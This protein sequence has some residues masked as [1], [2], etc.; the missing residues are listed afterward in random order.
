MLQTNGRLTISKAKGCYVW[1]LDNKKYLDMSLM[2]V[3]TN[4]LG[5]SNNQVDNAVIKAIRNSNMS[6]L[7]CPEEI[8]LSEKLNRYAQTF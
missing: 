8:H 2:S 5:Y 7:N 1:D 6:S 4:I 3:G